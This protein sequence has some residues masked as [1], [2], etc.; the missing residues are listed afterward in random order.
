MPLSKKRDRQRKR[1]NSNLSKLES[2]SNQPTSNLTGLDNR[3]FQ[4]SPYFNGPIAGNERVVQPEP[5]QEKLAE[6]RARIA[7]PEALKS[8]SSPV[9]IKLPLYN[10]DVYK[11]LTSDMRREYEER[12]VKPMYNPRIHR[13]GDR[14]RMRNAVGKLIEITVPEL[15]GEGNAVPSI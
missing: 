8:N 6:L 14:V 11:M 2:G 1:K 9:E 13:P 4:P 10:P 15:D 7:K 12:T 3:P 5:K